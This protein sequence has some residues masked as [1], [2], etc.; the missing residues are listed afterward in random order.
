[1][2]KL[3]AFRTLL[4]QYGGSTAEADRLV[5][6]IVRTNDLRLLPPLFARLDV[7]SDLLG[8]VCDYDYAAIALQAALDLASVPK[9]REAMLSFALERARWCASCATAGGEGLARSLHVHELE[10]LI[11]R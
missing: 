11:P 1:M 2:N 8:W 7:V 10:A 3:L 6:Q 5:E 4:E 9:I